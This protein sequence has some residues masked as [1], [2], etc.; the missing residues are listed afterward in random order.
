MAS[1]IGIDLMIFQIA[2][3]SEL[4]K[5][6]VGN[7]YTDTF[8]NYDFDSFA[9]IPHKAINCCQINASQKNKKTG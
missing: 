8:L 9:N 7:F 5:I 1:F 4:D 6:D 3:Y 2:S